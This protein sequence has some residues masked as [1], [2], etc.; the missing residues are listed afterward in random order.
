[1]KKHTIATPLK[2]YYLGTNAAGNSYYLRAITTSSDFFFI[3]EIADV[4]TAGHLAAIWDFNK[5][6]HDLRDGKLAT[7][8][9][10]CELQ[11]IEK[12]MSKLSKLKAEWLNIRNNPDE[13]SSLDTEIL[14]TWAKITKTLF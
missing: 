1:M 13:Y 4:S 8:F 9:T 11:K 7:P 2:Y 3:G 6:Q 5:F 14:T 10:D 12:T